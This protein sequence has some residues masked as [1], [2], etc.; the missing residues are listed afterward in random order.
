TYSFMIFPSRPRLYLSFI[1]KVPPA[2]RHF[3]FLFITVRLPCQDLCTAGQIHINVSYHPSTGCATF[4][5]STFSA[6][7]SWLSSSWLISSLLR[8]AV[9]SFTSTSGVIPVL[10]MEFPS[11]V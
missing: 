1:P 4:S 2:C 7:L 3:H 10:L 9:S 8:R 5:P 6:S 11:G